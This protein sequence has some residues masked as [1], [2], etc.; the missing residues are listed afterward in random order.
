MSKKIERSDTLTSYGQ[1]SESHGRVELP[2]VFEKIQ[3]G[4]PAPNGGYVDNNLDVNDFLINNAGSTFIYCV[5][6]ESMIEAGIMPGD[7][8]L[9]D[10]SINVRDGDIVVVSIDNEITIKELHKG[11]PLQFIPHNKEYSP[12]VIEEF[13]EVKII[14]TVISVVRKYR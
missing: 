14:G 6:G 3:A 2:L 11:P 13:N 10:S 1:A 8:V 12:I 5:N 7:Y 9:V 4:F